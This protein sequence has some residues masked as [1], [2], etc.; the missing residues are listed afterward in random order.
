MAKA[1]VSAII[2]ERNSPIV[3][4]SANR[5]AHT[6]RGQWQIAKCWFELYSGNSRSTRMV[7]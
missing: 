4:V 1:I 2:I 3:H 7:A 5:S 6:L